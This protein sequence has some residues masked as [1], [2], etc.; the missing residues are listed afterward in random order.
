MTTEK[1]A[2]D[3]AAALQ[4]Q[5]AMIGAMMAQDPDPQK[6]GM[7][8]LLSGF[9]AQ[10]QG[11][12]LRVTG[13][14]SGGGLAAV[15]AV[16]I[17]S[18]LRART[19]ANESAAIGDLR[20]LV[21]AQAAYQSV[22][23]GAYGELPCLSA[24]ASC[25]KGYSGPVFLDAKLTTLEAK[26]GYRRAFHAGRKAARARSVEAYAYTAVPV[27]PGKTGTRSFCIDSTGLIRVDPK[28]A[29]IRPVGGE[30]PPSLEPLK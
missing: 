24:P 14:A 27:E 29:E 20:T 28:G 22:N 21:S 15:M 5:L 19:S 3:G 26:S 23:E 11:K 2:Q 9:T 4:A 17:P 8:K 7:G 13:S 25:M 12:M 10:A 16:A 30:C 18:L 1:D 6:A